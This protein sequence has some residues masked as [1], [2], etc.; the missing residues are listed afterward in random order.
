VGLEDRIKRLE[1]AL[2][3]PQRE[4]DTGAGERL[5]REFMRRTLD[6]VAHIKRAPIDPPRWR[7]EVSHLRE[8]SPITVAAYVAALACGEHDD[9][10]E[11]RDILWEIQNDRG[12]DPDT[13]RRLIDAA[14]SIKEHVEERRCGA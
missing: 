13:L 12:T 11:A 4:E 14:M 5:L 7:Y 6:A 10:G 2:T 1:A 3:S 9:E 8:E